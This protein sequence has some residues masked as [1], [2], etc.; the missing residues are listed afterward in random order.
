MRNGRFALG[1]LN[2]RRVECENVRSQVAG[3]LQKV[4]VVNDLNESIRKS[5]V[6]LDDIK[7]TGIAKHNLYPVF[8][9]GAVSKCRRNSERLPGFDTCGVTSL[10]VSLSRVRGRAIELTDSHIPL[11]MPC[12]G[13]A[14]EQK[15]TDVLKR[16]CFLPVWAATSSSLTLIITRG[17]QSWQESD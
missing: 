9:G 3:T 13:S 14:G 17:R 12:N 5:G 11:E 7:T 10:D 16:D 15:I 4:D 8:C 6:M 2:E 1:R